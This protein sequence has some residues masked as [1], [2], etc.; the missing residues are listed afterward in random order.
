MNFNPFREKGIPLSEQLES[1]KKNSPKPYDKEITDP[2]TKARIILMNGIEVEAAMFLHQF[3]RNCSD[4]ELRRQLAMGRFLEQQHQKKMN[5]QAPP[6]ETILETTIGY[7]QL[8]VDLTSWLAQHEENEDV[9]A[10]LD[11]A[12]LEDF[13]HLYRY[14]DLLEMDQGIKAEKLVGGYTEIM[15]GRPTIA[16]HRNPVDNVKPYSDSK[17]TSLQTKLNTHIIVAG[18]QQT[19]NYYNNVGRL[20]PTGLGRD[21]YLEIG[22]VEEEHVTQYGSLLDPNSTWLENMV[23][24]E[25]TE[26]YLYHSF[27]MTE[28]DPAMKKIWEEQL[29]YEVAHLQNA[30]QLLEKIEK[31]SYLDVTGQEE[32]PSILEL[33]SNVDYVRSVLEKTVWIT[34]DHEHY[35]DARTLNGK[36]RFIKHNTAINQG[37]TPSHE[38]IIQAIQKNGTDY[39]YQVEDHPI[40]ELQ[41]RK[42]DNTKVGISGVLSSTNSS[43]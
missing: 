18:E 22:M 10:S 24:H 5:W 6:D 12:L 42:D 32:F 28:S 35:I 17:K 29:M 9:K 36:N 11:F 16:H 20:Y 25:Y 43:K 41:D 31:K 26:C 3:H 2:Y 34:G 14:A 1:W 15:P 38:V 33:K 27:F 13:D 40:P 4:N 21:L 8:A 39:R 23:M 7:E 37:Y 30:A 19:M